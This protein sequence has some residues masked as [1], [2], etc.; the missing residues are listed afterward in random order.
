MGLN[1]VD[2]D[3]RVQVSGLGDSISFALGILAPV[4]PHYCLAK[5]A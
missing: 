3:A 1:G 2:L 4:L 5:L